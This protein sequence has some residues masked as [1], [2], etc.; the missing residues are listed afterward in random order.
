MLQLGALYALASA[1]PDVESGIVVMYQGEAPK[2]MWKAD[3]GDLRAAGDDQAKIEAFL[4]TVEK[5][6]L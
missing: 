6:E 3:L 5:T 2:L 4:A 1:A